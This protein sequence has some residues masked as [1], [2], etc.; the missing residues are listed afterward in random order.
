MLK[1]TDFLT[2]SGLGSPRILDRWVRQE[3]ISTQTSHAH[4]QII[5]INTEQLHYRWVRKQRKHQSAITEERV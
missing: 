3:M 2:S 4:H 1:V 5:L